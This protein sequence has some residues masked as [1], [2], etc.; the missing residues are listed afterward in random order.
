V[1]GVCACT[2]T[3]YY[4]FNGNTLDYTGNAHTITATNV[5]S[6]AGKLGTAFSFNGTTSLMTIAGSLALT[7]NRT[8][9]AWINPTG[10][11]GLGRPVFVGGVSGAGDFLSIESTN[12]GGACAATSPNGMFLDHWGASCGTTT[13]VAPSNTWSFVCYAA[14]GAASTEF[15]VNGTSTADAIG[16]FTYNLDTVTVGSNT[17]GGTTNATAFLGVIDEVSLWNRTLTLAEMNQL[18]TGTPVCALQ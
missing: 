18:Y 15:F 5:T 12:P 6:V 10:W 13:E 3:A 16:L 11:T 7:D 8:F 14:N 17:I 9:C 2:A 1:A 4:P